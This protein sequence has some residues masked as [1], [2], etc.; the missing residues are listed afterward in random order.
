MQLSRG[1]HRFSFR[2]CFRSF[3]S[4]SDAV[5]ESWSRPENPNA[6]LLQ[7]DSTWKC[8]WMWVPVAV[9]FIK[10]SDWFVNI[11]RLSE[12]QMFCLNS[13]PASPSFGWYAI[14][15]FVCV[16]TWGYACVG[17]LKCLPRKLRQFGSFAAKNTFLFRP[18]SIG[19]MPSAMSHPDVTLC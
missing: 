17:L 12:K 2:F 10:I 7:R 16:R 6:M 13:R 1:V 8:R 5:R 15:V 3:R 19:V 11:F 9:D 14:A 4:Y 18:S